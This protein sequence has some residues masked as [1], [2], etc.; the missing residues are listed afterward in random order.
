MQQQ[1]RKLFISLAQVALLAAILVGI[2]FLAIRPDPENYFAGSLLQVELLEKTPS[3]RII[4]IGG[5]NVAF[6]LDA[7]LMQQ[8]LAM[9]VINDGLHAGLG[10]APLRELVDYIRA[11]DVIIIS[12]EYSMFSA[13]GVMEGDPSV[14]SDWVEYSVRRTRYLTNPWVETPGL[15]ATMLQRKVNRQIN[16]VL[17]GGSLS[18]LRTVFSGSKFDANGDFTGHLEAES[19]ARSKISA[20]PYPVSATQQELFAFLEDFQR[21]AQALGVRVYFEAP[22]SRQTNCLATGEKRME[23]FFREFEKKSSIPLI[24]PLN[25]V[26]MLDRYFFDTPYHLNAQGRRVRTKQLIKNLLQLNV[27]SNPQ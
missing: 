23:N 1:L 8:T 18:E 22:A 21:T 13:E 15:Y 7:E 12:L 11:G 25:E 4:L 5:S 27:V 20:T 10:V 9:P 3:P 24:T 19:H 16:S 14:L 6:G 26:C 17:Y 2:V